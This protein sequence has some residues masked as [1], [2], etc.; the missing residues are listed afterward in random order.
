MNVPTL[1]TF[2]RILLVPLLVIIMLTNYENMH[3]LSFLLFVIAALTDSLDGYIARKNSQVTVLGQLLDPI[4][5]KL[6]I[7][8]VLICMVELNL[9]SAWIVVVI[10]SRE[11]AVTGFRSMASSKGINIPAY[12][13]GKLKMNSETLTIGALLL[14]EKYLGRFY[15]LTNVGWIVVIAAALLSAL[16]YFIKFGPQVILDKPD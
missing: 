6:L 16:Q 2:L 8:S 1:L 15:A 14:G 7:S 5:D 9:V 3:L 4:A 13:L 10:I 11:I 12:A